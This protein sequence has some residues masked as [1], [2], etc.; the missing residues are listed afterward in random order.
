MQPRQG[1]GVVVTPGVHAG[2]VRPIPCRIE[3]HSSVGR[4]VDVRDGCLQL[5]PVVVQAIHLG[6]ALAIVVARVQTLSAVRQPHPTS[7]R[8][9][10]LGPG[11]AQP[12]GRHL[13]PAVTTVQALPE[14][15]VVDEPRPLV[16]ALCPGDPDVSCVVAEVSDVLEGLAAVDAAEE[17]VAGRPVVAGEDEDGLVVGHDHALD[18][19]VAV[20]A[21]A[22]GPGVAVVVAVV[23]P[24]GAVDREDPVGRVSAARIEHGEP[25]GAAVE[26]VSDGGPVLAVEAALPDTSQGA[27]GVEPAA[28]QGVGRHVHAPGLVLGAA[29][30]PVSVFWP[31]GTPGQQAPLLHLGQAVFRLDGLV[32]HTRRGLVKAGDPLLAGLVV[33]LLHVR[34]EPVLSR[35]RRGQLGGVRQIHAGLAPRDQDEGS[36]SREE[37]EGGQEQ[38]A[39]HRGQPRDESIARRGG[40]LLPRACELPP[41]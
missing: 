38:R 40:V 14:A 13:V 41:A 22:G 1:L 10:Q 5:S 6:P 15:V 20:E 9:G 23:E 7:L 28:V 30:H 11:A 27:A 25:V 21:I 39:A 26:A 32:V 16:C 24:R 35:R 33:L 36:P 2:E 12:Q 17:R 3:L 19:P 34:G 8:D 4:D 18:G 37:G 29:L 31:P